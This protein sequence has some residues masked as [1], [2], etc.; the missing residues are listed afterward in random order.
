[1]FEGQDNPHFGNFTFRNNL[2]IRVACKGTIACPNVK[3]YNNTFV[4]CATNVA[5]AP[6]TLIF[7]SATN[8]TWTNVAYN[9]GHGGKVFNNVF[10][11]CSDTNLTRG[12]YYFDAW[13]TNVQADYNFV[14]K[15]NYQGVAVDS[16]H[17]A[18]GNPGGWNKWAWWEPHGI[19]GGNPN[20]N[21]AA[22]G[23]FSPGSNSL[24]YNAGAN[25]SSMFSTDISARS[26]PFSGGWTIGAYE[27]TKS[28]LG[29]VPRPTNLHKQPP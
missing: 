22:N 2:F 29:L 17:R 27:A 23:D 19:N 3:W 5:A 13:L 11:N 28:D 1:M 8:S 4:E 14:A 25:L 20:F 16:L 9:T 10:F 7:T 18:I 21:N 6:I 26:R 15:N 24:L 12:W